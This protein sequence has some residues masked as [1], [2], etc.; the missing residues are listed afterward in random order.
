M[1]NFKVLEKQEQFKSNSSGQPDIIM[2]RAE[3]NE[4]ENELA[5]GKLNKIHKSLAFQD[6]D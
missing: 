4:M 1:V 6:P 5:L 2:I 3:I